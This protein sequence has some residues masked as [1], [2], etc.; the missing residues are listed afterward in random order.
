VVN[1]MSCLGQNASKDEDAHT[2]II[3]ISFL[4]ERI[5]CL[6]DV[7]Q[8]A[9]AVAWFLMLFFP[10]AKFNNVYFEH[11]IASSMIM[12]MISPSCLFSTDDTVCVCRLFCDIELLLCKI[13]ALEDSQHEIMVII[14]TQKEILPHSLTLL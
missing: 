11:N 2:A 5:S 14:V 12:R 10:Q 1:D 4:F 8:R 6:H 3:F 9:S 13:I 7:V